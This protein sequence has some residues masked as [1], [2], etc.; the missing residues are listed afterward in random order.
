LSTK[1]YPTDGPG[2][3]GNIILDR[4]GR[5]VWFAPSG[6]HSWLGFDTQTYKGQPV[7]T[8]WQ[9]TVKNGYGKGEGVIADASYQTIATVKA[10]NG[11]MTDLHEFVIT[12]QDTAL[13]TAYRT[14]PADLSKLGGKASGVVLSG[15]VQ[16]INIAT[17]R[18]L[19]EWDS[20]DHVA[21]ADTM[22]AF[23]GG[24]SKLPFD[25]FHINSI[26]IAPDGD[27]LISARNTCAI[28]KVS[29][30]GGQIVWRLGGKQS[31][32]H[33]GQGARFYF[34]HHARPHGASGLSIFD[35]G[36]SPPQIE[37]Q[38]RAILL[39]L[40]TSA[41]TATL[42]KQ[43]LHP[44][45]VAAA[46]QGSMQ[47]LPDGRVFV[48]WGNQPYFSEFSADGKI[49]LEGEF[50]VGDQSYRAFTAAWHGRPTGK[51]AVVA[52]VN[53]AG[54]TVVYVSWNGATDVAGWVVRGGKTSASLAQVGRQEWLGFET[55]IA[56]ANAGP[57]FAVTAVDAQGKA[58]GDSEAVKVGNA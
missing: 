48:G 28:Y 16:E 42:R 29:R 5:I 18:V 51:P 37:K 1:G 56:V 49:R 33:M 13:I 31:S 41:M 45:G 10:G 46:N 17:G 8:W 22:T 35:D 12:P 39:D 4:Q 6:S 53:P 3:P 32:F 2:Q 55:A 15:V 54:G 20:L 23:T 58:L 36:G 43:Y 25:Y 47:V 26:A 7:L 38:S 57:Y 24:T 34:Q 50:P 30:P 40:D 19:F 27:L 44:A 9:G 11:V 52:R 14:A 21:P